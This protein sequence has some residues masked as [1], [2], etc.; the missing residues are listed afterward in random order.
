[1]LELRQFCVFWLKACVFSL[2]RKS[3]VGYSQ[4]LYISRLKQYFLKMFH[5]E[6]IREANQKLS[7]S[8]LPEILINVFVGQ[9]MLK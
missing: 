8:L 9:C 5:L 4:M 7:L 3:H 1:M 6:L 2:V